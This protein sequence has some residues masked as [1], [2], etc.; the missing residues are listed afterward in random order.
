MFLFQYTV[1]DTICVYY[2]Y[3]YVYTYTFSKWIQY[4]C[5][6]VYVCH[7]GL[8]WKNRGQ[9]L[10]TDDVSSATTF[11]GLPQ[12]VSESVSTGIWAKSLVGTMTDKPLY[13]YFIPNWCCFVSSVSTYRREFKSQTSDHMDRW[14]AETGRVKKKK[15]RS[16]KRRERVCSK[17]VQMCH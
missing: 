12:A 3:I 7:A 1:G 5:V 4:P 8:V 13:M 16:E 17:K 2:I 11:T 6:C 15:R 14:K 10:R 9:A